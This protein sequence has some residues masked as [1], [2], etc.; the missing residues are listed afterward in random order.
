MSKLVTPLLTLVSLALAADA[1]AQPPP[2]PCYVV[3]EFRETRMNE[4]YRSYPDLRSKIASALSE[5]LNNR[6]PYWVFQ[7]RD[8]NSYPRL[9][10]WI[11]KSTAYN[12]GMCIEPN[13]NAGEQEHWFGVLWSPEEVNQMGG[14]TRPPDLPDT[15][16][17]KFDQNVMRENTPKI[18]EAV[19][20]AV[21]LIREDVPLAVLLVSK[22]KPVRAV[23]PLSWNRYR[24]LGRANFKVVCKGAQ[25]RGV[26]LY[27]HSTKQ[28]SHFSGGDAAFDAVEIEDERDSIYQ[29]LADL[30]DLVVSEIY[31]QEHKW[32]PTFDCDQA[33]SDS[34]AH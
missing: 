6:I 18:E 20:Q 12:I 3:F 32:E 29:H 23:L 26:E 8:E 31:L 1:V 30:S 19:R 34:A 7:F 21:P 13:A 22:A 11:E 9:K 16:A 27:S 25:H 14:F 33:V 2:L 4:W 17:L 24:D 28:C 10:V 15:I 5:R